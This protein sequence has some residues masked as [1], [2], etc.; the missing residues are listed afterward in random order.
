MDGL[1]LLKAAKMF[2]PEIE[3]ILIT[4]H[5]EVDIAVEAMRNGAFHFISKPPKRSHI[6]M[7]VARALEK[8]ALGL[9]NQ[10]YSDQLAA[11]HQGERIFGNSAVMQELI[12]EVEQIASS[13]ANVLILGESGTGKEVIADA[14]HA[15]SL[16]CDK[17]MVKINCAAIP[18]DLLESDLFG[19]ERG[20]FTSAN[21]RKLGR[22][23]LANGG[24]LFL[25]EIGD[26]SM[27]LQSKPR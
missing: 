9:E 11:A 7:T 14:L 12:A 25:D 6:L 15:A 19:H 4:G 13:D 27:D 3:V 24:T 1:Q 16:R 26:M 23:E 5:G 20:A 2:A 21:E 10:A 17:A 18:E 8:H 22:F